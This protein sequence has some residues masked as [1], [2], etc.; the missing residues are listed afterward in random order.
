MEIDRNKLPEDV[1]ALRQMV[2]ALL[3][4]VDSKERRLQ[5]L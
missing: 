2:A 1:A 5:Q 3:E 4:E